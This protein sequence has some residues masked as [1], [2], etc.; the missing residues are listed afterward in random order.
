MNDLVNQAKQEL[1]SYDKISHK[2]T[3]QLIDE[4]ERLQ[5]GLK[6]IA[7]NTFTS[8][9]TSYCSYAYDILNP[10]ESDE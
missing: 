8:D 1:H 4:I 6:F 2:T 9:D 7:D 10:E 3:T 5:K